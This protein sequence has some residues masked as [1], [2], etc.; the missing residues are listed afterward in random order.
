MKSEQK[1]KKAEE[2]KLSDG[3]VDALFNKVK[4]DR[5]RNLKKDMG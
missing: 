4:H 5:I 1:R 3:D 2:K